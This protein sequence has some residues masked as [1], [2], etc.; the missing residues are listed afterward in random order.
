MALSDYLTGDEWDGC[1]Y[2]MATHGGDNFGQVMHRTIDELLKAGHEFPGLDENGNKEAQVE[3][4]INAP[5][6]LIFL[7]NPEGINVEAIVRNGRNFIKKEAPA[8]LKESDEEW[9][10]FLRDAKKSAN[11]GS[12]ED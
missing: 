5:K 1:F 7:G 9:E 6:V 2:V 11:E 8:L 3:N 4:G 10:K 12:E